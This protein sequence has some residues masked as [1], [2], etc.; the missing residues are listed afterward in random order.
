MSRRRDLAIVL[1]IAAVAHFTY[2]ALRY[3]SF[4]FPDSFTYLNPAKNLAHGMGFV[5][6]HPPE[7]ETIRTP[8]YPL[9]LMLFGFRTPLVIAFQH[10]L[11]VALA[12]VLYQRLRQ[13]LQN[14][15][16]AC[17][18]AILFALDTPTIHIA[19]KLL[20]ESVFTALLFLVFLL[21]LRERP[22]SVAIGIVIGILVLIRP[23]AMFFF[24]LVA[25]RIP[26]RRLIWFV[27]AS[28]ALPIAWAGRNWARAG[29]FTVSSVGNINLLGTRAAGALAIEDEGDDFRADLA[30]EQKGLVEDADDWIQQKLHIADAEELPVAVR[31]KYYGAFATRVIAQH[32]IAFAELTA[33]GILVNLFDSD[34]DALLPV[35]RLSP[36]IV[37]L[38]VGVLPVAVFIFAII[39]IVALWRS[40]RILAVAIVLTAGYFVFMSAGAEAEYRFRVPVMPQLA[41]AAA[42]GLDVVRRAVASLSSVV[43]DM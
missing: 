17:A 23:I 43:I 16:A 20:T 13:R 1:A 30:D 11:C 25:L 33:R 31:V 34:W 38:T 37:H 24:P 39:G 21:A 29:V 35:T 3:G 4:Y 10:L 28:L 41:I 40:D 42:V 2:F 5:S 9:L 8:A 6:G 14:R 19:N 7:P 26:R 18:A 22:P 12:G 32:P 36:S 15:F 27:I